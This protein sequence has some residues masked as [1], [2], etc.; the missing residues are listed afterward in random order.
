MLFTVM[1]KLKIQDVKVEKRRPCNVGEANAR[2]LQLNHVS[3]LHRSHM[4]NIMTCHVMF[5]PSLMNHIFLP[6]VWMSVCVCV[7]A[8]HSTALHSGETGKME[9]AGSD[10]PGGVT[11]TCTT[12]V[13]IVADRVHP[14]MEPVHPDGLWPHSAE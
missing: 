2:C 13:D 6:I 9:A 11:L 12:Y 3:Y 8:E 4:N 7:R 1:N 14:F 10:Q 5:N